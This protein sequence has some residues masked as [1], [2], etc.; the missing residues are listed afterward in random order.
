MRTFLRRHDYVELFGWPSDVTV[1]RDR[2]N[3]V[4]PIAPGNFALPL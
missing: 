4:A 3:I 1:L 2:E